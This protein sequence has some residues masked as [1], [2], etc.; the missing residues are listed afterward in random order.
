MAQHKLT[1]T[2]HHK[3]QIHPHYIHKTPIWLALTFWLTKWDSMQAFPQKNKD[4]QTHTNKPITKKEEAG[5]ESGKRKKKWEKTKPGRENNHVCGKARQKR[6]KL[7][8]HKLRTVI[9]WKDGLTTSCS[10]SC[11]CLRSLRCCITRSSSSAIFVAFSDSS[12]LTWL[13]W[14]THQNP[15]PQVIS[16]TH[17]VSVSSSTDFIMCIYHITSCSRRNLHPQ[18]RG[19]ERYEMHKSLLKSF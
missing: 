8:S 5:V 2:T 10:W 19:T 13:D 4:R 16:N 9:E 15:I 6:N 14:D 7:F 12:M 3:D 11:V 18:A 17:I 1:C